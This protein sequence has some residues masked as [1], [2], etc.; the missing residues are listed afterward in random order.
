MNHEIGHLPFQREVTKVL[1]FG[2]INRVTLACDNTLLQD[3]VPQ[4]TVYEAET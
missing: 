3:T 4:G 1:K 2:T